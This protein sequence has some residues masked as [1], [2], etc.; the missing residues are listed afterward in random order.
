MVSYEAAVAAAA[1]D[2][3]SEPHKLARYR[4]GVLA[5]GLKEFDKA[6]KHL[7]ELAAV[8]FSYRDVADRLDKLAQNR[9]T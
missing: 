9:N 3:N 1:A 5:T 4:A 2:P 8:D 7:T 6:E